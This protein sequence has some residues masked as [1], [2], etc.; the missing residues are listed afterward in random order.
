MDR[1]KI[2]RTDTNADSGTFGILSVNGVPLC[3]TLELFWRNNMRN[4]SCIPADVYHC[5]KH[6]SRPHDWRVLDVPNRS[7]VLF[8]AG[9]TIEDIEGCILFGEQIARVNGTLGVKGSRNARAKF[10]LLMDGKKEFTLEI[11]NCF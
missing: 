2:V 11:I 9:N 1:V 3:N 5:T 6:E 7:G 10:N 4:V 8:H